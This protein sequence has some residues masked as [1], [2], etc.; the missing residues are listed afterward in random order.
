MASA[1]NIAKLA[2]ISTTLREIM[3]HSHKRVRKNM[4]EDLFICNGNGYIR[5]YLVEIKRG[6]AIYDFMMF[7]KVVITLS[8]SSSVI[9]TKSGR[10]I[11]LSLDF[12]DTGRDN[13]EHSFL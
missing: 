10:I 7:R 12:S 4:K 9:G 1:L 2:K 11:L 13:P 5:K 3:S 6:V 8:W